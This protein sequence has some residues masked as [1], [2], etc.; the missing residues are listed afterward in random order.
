MHY[1]AGDY[2]KAV[3]ALDRALEA[4][5]VPGE[6]GPLP[7]DRLRALHLRPLPLTVNVL[8]YR[9]LALEALA[10]C[11]SSPA[12]WLACEKSYALAAEV[13]DWLRDQVLE[14]DSSKLSQGERV[15]TLVP[16]RLG[17]S[18]ADSSP[19]ALGEAEDLP[20]AFGIAEQGP[21]PRLFLESLGRANATRLGGLPRELREEEERLRR[22]LRLLVAHLRAA[23]AET[24]DESLARQRDLWQQRRGAE[25]ELRRFERKLLQSHPGYAALRYPQPCSVEEARRCLDDNEVALLFAVGEEESVAVVLH[26]QADPRDPAAGLAVVLLPGRQ[27]LAGKVEAITRRERLELPDGT[28]ELGAARY[29]D[30][31]GPLADHIRGRNLLVVADG[32][33][34]HLPFELLSC[35]NGRYLIEKHRVRYAPSLTALHLIRLWEEGRKTKPDRPLVAFGDPVFDPR[36]DRLQG[37]ETL[38]QAT[39]D[40]LREVRLR[41]GRP[42]EKPFERLRASGAEVRA[43]AGLLGAEKDVYLGIAASEAKVKQLSAEGGLA[44][45]RYV[46]FATHGILGLD[47]GEPPALVLAQVNTTGKEDGYGLDDGFLTLQ[48]VSALEVERRPGDAE[49]LP[50]RG[51]SDGCRRG[52]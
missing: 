36:D 3:A 45:A 13:E 33:L 34:C 5:R 23:L 20:R 28:R 35:P 11:V 29:R 38:T 51:G 47:R 19:C 42:A 30:L 44:R 24:G 25:E 18:V 9:G 14:R 50:N 26:K 22:Q 40:A 10:E 27:A 8:Y 32:P 39:R 12:S 6:D 49:R 21:G 37:G 41:E 52:G 46:H 4:L 43:I 16:R 17:V 2:D 1:R 15:A 31:L 7:F 48:E